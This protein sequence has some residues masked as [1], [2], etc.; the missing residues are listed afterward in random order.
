MQ[1]LVY[2]T[3]FGACSWCTVAAK[4]SLVSHVNKASTGRE[5]VDRTSL[6]L[7][8]LIDS[9][10]LCE[11]C[12]RCVNVQVQHKSKSPHRQTWDLKE[13]PG[14][15]DLHVA[16]LHSKYGMHVQMQRICK[17]PGGQTWI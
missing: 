2:W 11:P 3:R 1:P 14:S 4:Q 5:K 13:A 16:M 10:H 15:T 17:S 6:E 12:K 8:V 7:E 9:V